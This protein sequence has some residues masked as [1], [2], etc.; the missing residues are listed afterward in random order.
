MIVDTP[1]WQHRQELPVLPVTI[2]TARAVPLPDVYVLMETYLTVQTAD[3]CTPENLAR[4][5]LEIAQEL[6]ECVTDRHILT[7]VID[8]ARPVKTCLHS[9]LLGYDYGGEVHPECLRLV[10]LVHATERAA[11]NLPGFAAVE[12]VS[13]RQYPTLSWATPS[14][15][16]SAY[17]ASCHEE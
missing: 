11:F 3:V 2:G 6:A 12:P 9:T 10:S 13:I 16:V 5:R 4:T 1:F 17:L 8:E 7:V 14:V 15:S